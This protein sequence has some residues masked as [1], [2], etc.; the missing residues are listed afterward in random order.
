[1]ACRTPPTLWAGKLSITTTSPAASSGEDLLDISAESVAIHWT[2]EHEGRG[3]AADPQ[4]GGDGRRLPM[5]VR[6]SGKATVAPG[7]PTV[8]APH[9]RG[10]AGLVNEHEPCRI[11]VELTV[12]PR[13]A[14]LHMRG[15]A[16]P[17]RGRSFFERDPVAIE[18]PPQRANPDPDAAGRQLLPELDKRDVRRLGLAEDP[19]KAPRSASIGGRHPAFAADVAGLRPAA[20]SGSHSTR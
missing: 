7:R 20:A 19:A 17:R 8:E 13:L 1:M 18:E 6:D 11:E 4:R 15:V 5:A 16:A 2:V 14:R 10:G 12:E 3:E 9:L